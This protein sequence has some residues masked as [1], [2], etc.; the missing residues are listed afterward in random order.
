MWYASLKYILADFIIKQY[1]LYCTPE[2][3]I[4]SALGSPSTF[5]L[6]HTQYSPK[7]YFKKTSV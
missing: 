1:L 7:W 2:N 5:Q 3:S 6:V 4:C